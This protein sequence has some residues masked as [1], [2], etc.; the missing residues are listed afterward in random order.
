MLW[1]VK[2][3]ALHILGSVHVLPEEP[4]FSEAEAMVLNNAKVV[5]FEANFELAQ[6]TPSGYFRG[7]RTLDQEVPAALFASTAELWSQLQ[8]DIPLRTV[9]PWWAAFIIMNKLLGKEG[10][11][12]AAGVDRSILKIAKGMKAQLFY[13]EPVGAGT[14]PFAS[15]PPNEQVECLSQAVLHSKEGIADVWTMTEA[16]RSRNPT[17]LEAMRDKY[18]RLMPTAYS[19]A[20]GGRN[21]SWL[22]RL[23]QLAKGVKPAVAVVGA[24]HLMGEDGI[25]EL[26]RKAGYQCCLVERE[27]ISA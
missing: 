8:I 4:R 26:L 17:A 1:T 10:L 11:S 9:R 24:M 14:A 23:V 13:L 7:K 27:S 15:A 18:L 22:P 12:H 16:W 3:T 19:A 25:S 20:L 21:R 2:S 5:A 6:G